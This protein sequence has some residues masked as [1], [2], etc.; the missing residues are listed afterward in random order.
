MRLMNVAHS[1]QMRNVYLTAL[2]AAVAMYV[3][4][5]NHV[6]AH[7]SKS[8]HRMAARLDVPVDHHDFGVVRSGDALRY[9]FPIRN[10]GHKR[11]I[12][13][14]TSCGCT[15]DGL[16]RTL[17]LQP[18]DEINFPATL[19]TQGRAGKL[20]RHVEL[21]TSDPERPQIVFT[22][23]AIAKK[24]ANNEAADEPLAPIPVH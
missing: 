2:V 18:G 9:E 10:L 4:M 14:R 6:S 7:H 21:K 11:V 1:D 24:D 19:S 16:A 5:L 8:V 20:S 22:L 23:S 15:D 3:T 12:L 17:I 13:N